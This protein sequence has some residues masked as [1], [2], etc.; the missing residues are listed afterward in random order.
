MAAGPLLRG[1]P[2]CGCGRFYIKNIEVKSQNIFLGFRFYRNCLL[3]I[4][5]ALWGWDDICLFCVGGSDLVKRSA[6]LMG[7]DS[8]LASVSKNFTNSPKGESS[9]FL[10][11]S[12]EPDIHCSTQNAHL[13]TRL[14]TAKSINLCIPRSPIRFDRFK[15]QEGCNEVYE[16]RLLLDIRFHQFR[17]AAFPQL[18]MRTSPENTSGCTW[19]VVRWLFVSALA[20]LVLRHMDDRNLV[21]INIDITLVVWRKKWIIRA[22]DCQANSTYLPQIWYF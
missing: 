19:L 6:L 15:C 10:S 11:H 16:L 1:L 3:N 2:W 7:P 14:W 22:I 12:P 20:T 9:A 18:E 17:T 13:L 8:T 21:H 5:F 4:L